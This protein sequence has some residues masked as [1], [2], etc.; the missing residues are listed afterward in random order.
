MKV[1]AGVVLLAGLAT[2]CGGDGSRAP[3]SAPSSTDGPRATGPFAVFA[4]GLCPKLRVYDVGDARWLVFGT[5]GLEDTAVGARDANRIGDPHVPAGQSFVALGRDGA[6]VMRDASW[7]AGLPLDARGYVRGDVDVGGRWP[8]AAWLL[9][10]ETAQ[11][12]AESGVLLE[13]K[14]EYYGW[15]GGAWRED[16]HARDAATSGPRPPPFPD[17]TI[18]AEAGGAARFENYASGRLPS[19]DTM[20]VGRCED[21]LH[22]AKG[23][24][25]VASVRAGEGQWRVVLAP[26]SPIFDSIVNFDVAMHARDDVYVSGYEPYRTGRGP[27]YLVH[28]DGTDW[29]PVKVPFGGQTVAAAAAPDGTLWVVVEW[30][31]LWR[32]APDGRWEE[33][34]LPVPAGADKLRLLEVYVTGDDTWV[35]AAYPVTLEDGA[36]AR[37]HVLYGTR[38]AARPLHCDKRLPADR[39]LG[40]R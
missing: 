7:F 22:R 3:A 24:A 26:T 19:G 29:G 40:P 31:D 32:R 11:G 17:D 37:R 14:R 35:H 16:P 33:V 28:F 20:V 10:V 2:G 30:R 39:A 12:P 4:E 36:S 25:L 6:A 8:D 38:R 34:S 1:G 21:E 23:G 9:R 15:T 13:R 18:C 5:Y 27:T